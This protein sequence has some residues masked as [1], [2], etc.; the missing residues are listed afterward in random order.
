MFGLIGWQALLAKWVVISL[1]VTAFAGFFYV[2]G[3]T[4]QQAKDDKAQVVAQQVYIDALNASHAKERALQA[5]VDQANKDKE[6]RDAKIKVLDHAVTVANGKL[7]DTLQALNNSSN[8]FTIDACVG[9][10]KTVSNILG[11]CS[12]KYQLM[13]RDA[14]KEYSNTETLIQAWPK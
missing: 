14:D 5:K 8:N 4:H 2:K 9:S 3:I 11:D 1:L 12:E 13:A 10:L 6:I 7:R